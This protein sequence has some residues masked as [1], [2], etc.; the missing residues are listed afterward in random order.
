MVKKRRLKTRLEAGTGLVAGAPPGTPALS[1]GQP[2]FLLAA[3]TAMACVCVSVSFRLY[4][5][6]IWH[7]LVVGK[8]IWQLRSI[9]KVQLWT[10][11]DYGV[12]NVNPEWGFEA[13]IWPVWR[14]G[15]V[16]GLAAWRWATTLGAFAALWLASR[17]LGARGLT[18]F[19]V[20]VLSSL[21]YRQRSQVRP[22]TLAALLFALQLWILESRR[23]GGSDRSPWLVPI[24]WIWANT[25]ASYSIGF[26]MLGIHL[27]DAHFGPRAKVGPNPRALWLAAGA[28]A[29]VSFL[30]P[31]GWHALWRP[32]QYSFE[33]RHDAF[34][35]GIS[36]LM[37]LQWNVNISNGLPLLIAGWP[38]LVLWRWRRVGFDL[39][40]A[41]TCLFFTVLAFTAT[42]FVAPYALAAAPYVSRGVDEWVRAHRWPRWTAAP[43]TRA[44]LAS[45]ACVLVG[46]YEWTHYEGSLGIGFNMRRYPVAAC[47][48][49][50]AHGVRGR[51]VNSFYLGG[52]MLWRFWPDR[53]RLPFMSM[54]PED[55]T[56]EVRDL[57]LRAFSSRSGWQEFDRRYGVEYALLSRTHVDHYGLA[58]LLDA[59][60]TWSLVFVDDV[61]ALF[62]RRGGRLAPVAEK[63]GYRQ[64]PAGRARLRE[65]L[66]AC[67]GD[68]RRLVELRQE[69]ERQASSS[70][71]TASYRDVREAVEAMV[72]RAGAQPP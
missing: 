12:P 58:D 14:L 56:A 10:W 63:F 46:P 7:H 65:L 69:L 4:D 6:D 26:V 70:P 33:W 53:E 60:S 29:A 50:A 62:V 16:M 41:A 67:A 21:V 68:Q 61:A 5:Y 25:H 31:Y 13:L 49:M 55:K 34:M 23:H 47:D 22:E 19:V 43:W 44:G 48:F 39:V 59:D 38:L 11:P 32:F 52:Y 8:G 1:L 35:A 3:L 15:G 72:A 24:A 20:T 45:C 2:A 28:A 54:H 71:L 27:L 30:N 36:E 18:P 57:Y 64:L 66:D 42:R 37:P 40:D 9:P 17:R 51:S